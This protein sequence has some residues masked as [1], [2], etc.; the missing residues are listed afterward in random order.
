MNY[1]SLYVHAYTYRAYVGMLIYIRRLVKEEGREGGGK[2]SSD[3]LI[4]TRSV[5]C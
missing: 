1:D 3:G 2:E 4:R 5:Y